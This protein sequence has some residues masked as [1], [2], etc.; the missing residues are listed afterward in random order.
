MS[1]YFEVIN[2]YTRNVS[3]RSLV[4]ANGGSGQQPLRRPNTLRK[5]GAPFKTSLLFLNLIKVSSS[6]K[7][8]CY[9]YLKVTPLLSLVYLL[10]LSFK[11]ILSGAIT[12]ILK[13]SLT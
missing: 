8:K 2:L 5:E 4:L 13:Y 6:Y 1:L 3:F 9:K 10:R 11:Y 7:C 12:V